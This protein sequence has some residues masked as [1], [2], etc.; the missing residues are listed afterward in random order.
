VFPQ[1]SKIKAVIFDWD[2]TLLDS[3]S[4]DLAAYLAM[5]RVLKIAWSEED[6][7]RNYSPDWYRIYRAAQIPRENWQRAD[8]LWRL[9]YARQSTAL[10][11]GAEAAIARLRS[12]F[13]LGLVTSGSRTRVLRQLSGF[14]FTR[15]FTAR[16]YSES[17]EQRK[18][19]PA[20]LLM[21]LKKMRVA[22]AE[23]LY[24][25]DTPEDVEMA[26]SARV[27]AIGVTGPFPTHEK[28]RAARPLAVLKSVEYLPEMLELNG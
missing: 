3:Y 17:A 20:P 9:H 27:S 10:L 16:I 5:F 1:L 23:A 18:P 26:R 11:P 2:G 25:G 14:G 4:A 21:A 24:V 28:L 7:R 15:I 22:A 13:K 8:R 12:K 19:H 6:L